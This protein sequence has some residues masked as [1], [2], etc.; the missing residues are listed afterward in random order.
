MTIM[1]SSEQT[2]LM[3][4]NQIDTKLNSSSQNFFKS[5]PAI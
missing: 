2:S 5:F 1:I 4:I 3:K